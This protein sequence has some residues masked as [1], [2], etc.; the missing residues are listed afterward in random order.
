MSELDEQMNKLAADTF[1]KIGELGMENATVGK[2]MEL[3]AEKNQDK[4][5]ILFEE[6]K[7]TY[8][9]LDRRSNSVAS[10]LSQ[11]GV[12]KGERA[13]IMLPNCPQYLYSMLGMGKMGAIIIPVNINLKGEGLA[14]ILN[15]SEASTLIISQEY[16]D[17]YRFVQP[18]L[19]HV[20]RLVVETTGAPRALKLPRGSVLFDELIKSSPQRPQVDLSPLDTLST[21]YTSGTTGPPKGVNQPQFAVILGFGVAATMDYTPEDVLYTCLPFFHA[22]ATVLSFM[23][24]M[25][26]DATLAVSR[27]FSASRFWDEVRKY[28]ATEFNAL[29]AMLPILMKQPPKPDDRDNPVK[30]VFSAACPADIWEAFEERFGVEIVE[31]YGA[32][33]GCFVINRPTKTGWTRKVGSFGRALDYMNEVKV[34]DENDNEC[35]PNVVGE[36]ISKPTYIATEQVVEYYKMPEESAEKSRGG[37]LRTGDLVRRDEDGFFFFVGRKKDYIRR[38]GENISPWEIETTLAKHPAIMESAAIGV[39]SELGEDEVKVCVVLK[40]GA[41]LK[42]EELL[43]FCEDRMAYFM[44]PRYVEFLEE[45]PKTA[46]HRVIKPE[47]QKAGITPNTWDRE[48]AGYKL[49]RE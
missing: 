11:M 26:A 15:H 19:K 2:L 3:K 5:A 4:V 12:K 34:V 24:A 7:I 1:A 13:A 39:K 44:V 14:Y 22:N 42:P 30:L 49:K 47:L 28:N 32:V 8:N 20:A 43:S 35:P 37:W 21:M 10:G 45:L 48:K 29:G 40:P 18:E 6:Q 41:S 17:K 38:R 9:E 25:A 33:E 46:T 27:R 23:P 36:M 16:L 31:G